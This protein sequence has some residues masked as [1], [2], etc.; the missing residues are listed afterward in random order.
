M[1]FINTRLLIKSRHG[2]N[3]EESKFVN[4]QCKYSWVMTIEIHV[5]WGVD[6]QLKFIVHC[7]WKEVRGLINTPLKTRSTLC[8]TYSLKMD[9]GQRRESIGSHLTPLNWN[10]FNLKIEVVMFLS[11]FGQELGFVV[12][13]CCLIFA[14]CDYK[15]MWWG[16]F[17]WIFIAL[18]T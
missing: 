14:G 4:N 8:T 18:K 5:S 13:C 7:S 10:A 3:K 9:R 17:S 12:S 15:R 1:V 11:D 16:V 2:Q 6:I